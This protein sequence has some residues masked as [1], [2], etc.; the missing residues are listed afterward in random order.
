MCNRRRIRGFITLRAIL[1]LFI[2]ILIIPI[3]TRTFITV[4]KLNYDHDEVSNEIGLLQLRRIL[5]IS[6]D[7][8]N[9]GNSLEFIYEGN[10]YHLEEIN[11]RLVLSPGYQMFLNDVSDINFYEEGSAVYLEY[12]F[13]NKTYRTPIV[14]TEGIYLDEFSDRDVSDDSD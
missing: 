14:K 9:Y 2:V 4:S 5:L 8:N 1:A 6:Y 12:T 10:N 7:L 13:G 11:N 3:S